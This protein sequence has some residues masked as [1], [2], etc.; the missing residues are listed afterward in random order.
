MS[1][2]FHIICFEN[3]NINDLRHKSISISYEKNG[4]IVKYYGYEF[5]DENILILKLLAYGDFNE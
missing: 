5:K 3:S 1:S 4:I 2:P